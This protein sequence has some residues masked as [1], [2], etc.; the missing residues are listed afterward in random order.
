MMNDGGTFQSRFISGT[1]IFM[2][3]LR[4]NF[5]FLP[6]CPQSNNF[7]SRAYL[8]E[9]VHTTRTGCR[10]HL[11]SSAIPREDRQEGP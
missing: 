7:V 5:K 6:P 1:S 4:P 3:A 10:D 11:C 2:P 8:L 9:T